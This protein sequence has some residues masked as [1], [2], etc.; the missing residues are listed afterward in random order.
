MYPVVEIKITANLHLLYNLKI[1]A[2]T[3]HTL[4]CMWGKI[5]MTGGSF[6]NYKEDKTPLK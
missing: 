4:N 5:L 3:A 1:L 2:I 6:F